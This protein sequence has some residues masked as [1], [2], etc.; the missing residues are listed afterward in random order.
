MRTAVPMLFASATAA[1]HPASPALYD[2]LVANSARTWEP[3]HPSEH[4]FRGNA[5]SRLGN[6]N[7]KVG[8]VPAHMPTDFDAREQFSSCSGAIRNQLH[9]GSCWAFGAAETLSDNLCVAGNGAGALSA[10]DLVSCDGK[11]HGCH[12]GDLPDAW[13]YLANTGIAAIKNGILQFGAAEAGISNTVSGRAA[14]AQPPSQDSRDGGCSRARQGR[15]AGGATATPKAV[16]QG[17]LKTAELAA[18][19]GVYKHDNTTS[20]FPLG[21]HALKMVGWGQYSG[22]D[23]G[24]DGYFKIDMADRDSAFALG[25]AFNCGDLAAAPPGPATPAPPVAC[26][27]EMDSNCGCC[28]YMKPSLCPKA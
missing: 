8:A 20:N 28:S 23:W 4:V 10:Q 1:D 21:G 15:K 18:A 12:G 11:S 16:G 25:G 3:A 22:G 7:N 19:S 17:V 24:M 27:D 9:C 5:T 26:K 14:A 2:R 13:T 6:N